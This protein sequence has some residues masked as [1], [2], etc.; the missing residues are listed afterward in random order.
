[1]SAADQQHSTSVLEDMILMTNL[2]HNWVENPV[3]L[4]FQGAQ[5][6]LPS[7]CPL[8]TRSAVPCGTSVGSWE[9][10]FQEFAD[11]ADEPALRMETA[12]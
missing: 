12:R 3:V 1:M 11:E 8:A 5:Q 6:Y 7:R 4:A 10:F 2:P 9:Q